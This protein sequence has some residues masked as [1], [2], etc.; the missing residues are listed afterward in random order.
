MA[1]N[2]GTRSRS[3]QAGGLIPVILKAGIHS[4]PDGS[5]QNSSVT[6][7]AK[8]VVLGAWIDVRVAEATGGTK[9]LDVGPSSDP[10]GYLDGIDVSSTGLKKGT[11]DSGGQTLGALL[12]ADE[13]GSGA[14]VPESD[15]SAGGEV[16]QY[17]A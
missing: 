3:V 6:L 13:D 5:A 8:A 15:V 4:T 9:T 7:P 11:L 17:T 1:I 2:Y 12:T 16:V 10:N 14:L